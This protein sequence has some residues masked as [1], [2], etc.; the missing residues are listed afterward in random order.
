MGRKRTWSPTENEMQYGRKESGAMGIPKKRAR[1]F[2]PAASAAREAMYGPRK[3]VP[4]VVLNAEL[5]QSYMA[6]PKISRL[7]FTGACVVV[8]LPPE[9]V[10]FGDSISQNPVCVFWVAEMPE[11]VR[12]RPFAQRER[13]GNDRQKSL[14]HK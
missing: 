1:P 8:M 4:T 14:A 5:A 10:G 6:Q 12:I 2:G 13:V 3:T 11:C 7:S 9:R